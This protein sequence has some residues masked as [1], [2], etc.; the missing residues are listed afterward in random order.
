MTG[1][2]V[3]L[4]GKTTKGRRDG[5]GMNSEVEVEEGDE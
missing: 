3:W 2:R 1:W 5:S 4:I